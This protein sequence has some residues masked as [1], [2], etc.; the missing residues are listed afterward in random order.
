MRKTHSTDAPLVPVYRARDLTDLMV[1]RSLL[2][3]AGIK[4][5][6]RGDKIQGIFSAGTGG[7]FSSQ[8]PLEILVCEEDREEAVEIITD[9]L[10][11]S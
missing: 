6:V 8:P 10:A 7:M 4:C 9:S 5:H 3:A 1:R 11:K 2:E